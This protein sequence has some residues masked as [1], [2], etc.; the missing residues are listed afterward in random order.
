MVDN[1]TQKQ[2]DEAYSWEAVQAGHKYRQIKI[3]ERQLTDHFKSMDAW[4]DKAEELKSK[5][6][7]EIKKNDDE[8]TAHPA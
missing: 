1:P 8:C 3:L 6:A 7:Q 5:Q 2:I 4:A